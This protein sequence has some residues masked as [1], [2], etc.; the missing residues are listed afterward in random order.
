MQVQYTNLSSFDYLAATVCYSSWASPF[1]AQLSDHFRP[2]FTSVTEI[3]TSSPLQQ[4]TL[5]CL[6]PNVQLFPLLTFARQ[7]RRL[8]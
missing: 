5:L 3:E 6:P 1:S 2:C 4:A 7:Q 8:A